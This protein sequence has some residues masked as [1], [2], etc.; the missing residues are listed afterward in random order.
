MDFI[1]QIFGFAPDGG[2]GVFE[3]LLF[4][5]PIAGIIT[6]ALRRRKR[7]AERRKP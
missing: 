6:L 1:E 5:V 3:L 4:I 7:A 2:N